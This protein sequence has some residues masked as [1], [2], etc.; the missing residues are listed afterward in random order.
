M[1]IILS[2]IHGGLPTSRWMALYNE[3][4]KY[5][6]SEVIL[7][8]DVVDSDPIEHVQPWLDMLA[9]ICKKYQVWWVMGNHDWLL[10][11]TLAEQVGAHC[12]EHYWWEDVNGKNVAIHGHQ[13]DDTIIN[14]PV[15]SDVATSMYA[16]LQ[17]LTGTTL[18]EWIKHTEKA[19][20]RDGE[21]I[22]KGAVEFGK[23]YGVNNIFCGH[24]HEYKYGKGIDN[25]VYY[26]DGCCCSYNSTYFTIDKNGLIVLQTF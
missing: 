11:P 17:K 12:L 19:I 21:R 23:E 25:I 20:T 16:E 10:A 2:D 13:F 7:V 22:Q 24:V 26:N 14:H 1:K 6:P 4:D 9:Q 18:A 15:L 8:G 5:N 3:I